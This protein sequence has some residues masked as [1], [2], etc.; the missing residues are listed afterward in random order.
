MLG[1]S[2]GID[3][4]ILIADTVIFSQ[5]IMIA[6]WFLSRDTRL[7]RGMKWGARLATLSCFI[8]M[9]QDVLYLVDAVP[10][11]LSGSRA[12]RVATWVGLAAIGAIFERRAV[13]GK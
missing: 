5:Y 9:L 2:I 7:A 12:V 13:T 6:H 10:L 8:R 11:W 1:N 3:L 4:A